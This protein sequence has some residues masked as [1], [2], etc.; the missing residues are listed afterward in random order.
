MLATCP[1]ASLRNG[2]EAIRLAQQASKLTGEKNPFIFRTLAAALAETGRFEDA[3]RSAQKAIEMAKAA[4][5]QDLAG[6]LN[7]EL[8]R[9]QAGLPFHH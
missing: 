2:E 1:E 7:I 6:Q 3:S 9:Y 4:G 8:K 5:R